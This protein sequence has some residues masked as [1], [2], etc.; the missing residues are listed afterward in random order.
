MMFTGANFRKAEEAREF[1]LSIFK[2]SRAGGIRHY[3][4]GQEPNEAGTVMF[5]DL[6]L[7]DTWIAMLD[8]P[9]IHNFNFNEGVSL[10]VYC[11]DQAELDHYWD[12][13][14][15]DP[16]SGQCGWLKDR[17]GVCWQIV[18]AIMH[19]ML[20]NSPHETVDRLLATILSMKKF[21]IAALEQVYRGN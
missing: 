17:Y 5:S 3:G 2:D 9:N 20:Y 13:L 12:S 7:G 8:S 14:I 18:P 10:M 16:D 1:Y 21:D 4:P 15:A 19:D 6:V 11:Q